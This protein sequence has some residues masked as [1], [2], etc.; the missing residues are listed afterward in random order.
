MPLSNKCLLSIIDCLH[1]SCSKILGNSRIE[2]NHSIYSS[3]RA[4]SLEG[5][6]GG[7]ARKIAHRVNLFIFLTE[8]HELIRLCILF[9]IKLNVRTNL[10][11]GSWNF[12]N[13][14]DLWIRGLD[15][16]IKCTRY[17][18]SY[19]LWSYSL[20]ALV[21]LEFGGVEFNHDSKRPLVFNCPCFWAPKTE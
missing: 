4:S 10:W 2:Q 15:V 12:K 5:G 9:N 6:G 16:T 14:M 19:K 18:A 8:Y 21:F 7:G 13:G 1:N 20:K 3:L 11:H 17:C